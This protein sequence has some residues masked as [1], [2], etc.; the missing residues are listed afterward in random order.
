[1]LGFGKMFGCCPPIDRFNGQAIFS[2]L[3][4]EKHNNTCGHCGLYGLCG[5][6]ANQFSNYLC[7]FIVLLIYCILTSLMMMLTLVVLA[8]LCYTIY[9][10]TQKGPLIVGGYEVGGR[11]MHSLHAETL[12]T[13]FYTCAKTRKF[14]EK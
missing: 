6:C 13:F 7:L 12:F 11:I 10:R 1:M 4:G 5:K 14:L 8:G 9:Q 3:I 2:H